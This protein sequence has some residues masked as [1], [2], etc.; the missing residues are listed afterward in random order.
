[1]AKI[2]T[3][4]VISTKM[5]GTVI[6]E[7]TRFV[8]H[9]L[10]RKLMKKSKHHKV[11]NTGFEVTVGQQ[12]KIAETKPMAKDKHFK[13]VEIVIESHKKSSIAKTTVA[14][15]VVEDKEGKE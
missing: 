7:V 4:K 5:Q 8:P 12:V 1:M 15:K 13:I 9:K 14:K 6:V 3:G 10:Y 2:L 11:D